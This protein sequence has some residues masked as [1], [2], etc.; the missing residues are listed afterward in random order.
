[1]KINEIQNEA[2][3]KN[4]SK[5]LIFYECQRITALAQGD[6]SVNDPYTCRSKRMT[7]LILLITQGMSGG[8]IYVK[9]SELTL[10]QLV[11]MYTIL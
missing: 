5:P 10:Y 1:M 3:A 2:K 6:R 8:Y 11:K 9:E 7:I 4:T